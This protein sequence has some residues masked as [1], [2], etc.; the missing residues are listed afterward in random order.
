MIN[1]FKIIKVGDYVRIN[2]NCDNTRKP[3]YKVYG[4]LKNEQGTFYL[5]FSECGLYKRLFIKEELIKVK[6]LKIK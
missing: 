1:L 3:I 4:K 6:G 5:L 2:S